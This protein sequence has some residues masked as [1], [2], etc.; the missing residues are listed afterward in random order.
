MLFRSGS[1]AAAILGE[2]L[3]A[4]GQI[5]LALPVLQKLVKET[6]N[7]ADA[8]YVLGQAYA[9]SGDSALALTTLHDAL[10]LKPTGRTA[11]GMVRLLTALRD[12]AGARE[13]LAPIRT[14]L[15]DQP[16]LAE[17]DGL[18]L[19]GE[20]SVAKAENLLS[21]AQ[22]R[23]P[24][25]RGITVLLARIRARALNPA[26]GIDVISKWLDVTPDDTEAHILR[27]DLLAAQKRT[28]DAVA[29]Y[30]AV[31]EKFPDNIHVMNNLA[32][33]LKD[34]DPDQALTWAD[35]AAQLA[36]E[37]PVV[38]DTLGV[39][40]LTHGNDS[41]RA[42]EVLTKASGLAPK[43][44]EIQQIGRASCRERV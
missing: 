27:A 14:Y 18:I 7:S 10:K 11:I 20:G 26:A 1:S 25:D 41:R 43:V 9:S 39:L 35:K 16:V 4:T 2:T 36:P 21:E 30:K 22:T 32:W 17:L 3:V 15:K 13:L 28:D 19:S 37:S 6:P 24:K 23:F 38:L 31:A 42:Q 34:S 44:P 40:L 33:L 29:E 12:F 5:E 8:R